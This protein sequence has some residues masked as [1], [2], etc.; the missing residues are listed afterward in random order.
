M[1]K[2]AT[3]SQG[4]NWAAAFDGVD[5][6][7][8]YALTRYQFD[9]KEV[10]LQNLSR[11]MIH[12]KD[13]GSS[14]SNVV[15]LRS[16]FSKEDLFR[17]MGIIV[18][19]HRIARVGAGEPRHPAYWIRLQNES[20]FS[21]YAYQT[22]PVLPLSHYDAITGGMLSEDIF[23]LNCLEADGFVRKLKRTQEDGIFLM[24]GFVCH[25]KCRSAI[26]AS[27]NKRSLRR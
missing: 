6:M 14:K 5:R 1:I 27:E 25:E 26:N 9:R 2:S 18:S 23:I 11:T 7:L 15:P 4:Y 12:L 21:E 24:P 20:V 10:R 22:I 3:M 17:V 16:S 8:N 13:G 19:H